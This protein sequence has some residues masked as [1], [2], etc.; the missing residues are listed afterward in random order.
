[1]P[2]T[3]STIAKRCCALQG[4]FFV[5]GVNGPFF[6]QFRAEADGLEL[7]SGRG[8]LSANATAAQSGWMDW[9][10]ERLSA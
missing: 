3:G 4:D 6:P 10:A 9:I 7:L 5:M 2:L 1:M 8:P